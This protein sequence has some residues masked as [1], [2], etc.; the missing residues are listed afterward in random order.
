MQGT[1]GKRVGGKGQ[2]VLN[3]DI[4]LGS[5]LSGRRLP[6]D[7]RQSG[8][9]PLRHSIG[10]PHHGLPLD[11]YGFGFYSSPLCIHMHMYVEL[12]VSFDVNLNLFD[13]RF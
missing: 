1:Q 11:I 2:E 7:G 5:R 4:K 12:V 13:K 10:W 6:Y 9:C 8:V 3:G